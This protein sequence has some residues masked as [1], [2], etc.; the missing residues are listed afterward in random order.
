[1]TKG[2]L[3]AV[4]YAFPAL[5]GIDGADLNQ[6]HARRRRRGVLHDESAGTLDCPAVPAPGQDFRRQLEVP[7]HSP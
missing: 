5:I 1:M 7:R 4:G 6:L 3:G 2:S